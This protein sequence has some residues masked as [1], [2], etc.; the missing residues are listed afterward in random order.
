M[1]IDITIN[2]K[3]CEEIKRLIKYRL[4]KLGLENPNKRINY[5]H[6]YIVYEMDV[7]KKFLEMF[8][9][10]ELRKELIL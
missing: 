2:K 8:E 4:F 7:L 5:S 3:A 9:N 10:L 1:K 6:Q